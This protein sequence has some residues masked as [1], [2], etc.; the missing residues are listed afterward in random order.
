MRETLLR[1]RQAAT[2]RHDAALARWPDRSGDA[3][4]RE[5]TAV[6]DDLDRLAREA[7]ALD[8]DPVE[9]ARTWRYLGDACFDLA[10][11][12]DRAVL[13]RGADAY[14]RAGEVLG[15]ADP[16]E[17]AK[18]DFNWG[19]TLRAVSGGTDRALLEE[20]RLRYEFARETFR[21]LQPALVPAVG[22]ALRTLEAQLA[23]L[24]MYEQAAGAVKRLE[25]IKR[26]L[27]RGGA[28]AT[29]GSVREARRQL[30][31]FRASA[32][33]VSTL[34]REVEGLLDGFLAALYG[35]DPGAVPEAS[36]RQIETLKRALAAPAGS[37]EAASWHALA[38]MLRDR[39]DADVAAEK[40]DPARQQVLAPLLDELEALCDEEPREVAAIMD[41]L[42]R[43]RGLMDRILDIWQR[44]AAAPAAGPET[45]ADRLLRLLGGVRI[46]LGQETRE[47]N[48][49]S[50]ERQAARGLFLREG[51]AEAAVREAGRDEAR[52]LALEREVLRPLALDVHTFGLRRH[53]TLAEP[54][55][56]SGPVRPD[57]NRV[58]FV[59]DA[60]VRALVA[61]ACDRLG[62]TL[63]PERRSPY[64][65]SAPWDDL[66]AAHVTVFDLGVPDGRDLAAVC[67]ELGLALALGVPC[68]LV[69][70]DAHEAPFNVDV[71]VH[72]RLGGTDDATAIARMLDAAVYGA[73][74]ADA[75]GSVHAT[76]ELAERRF[77][78]PGAPAYVG[79]AV[80]ELAEASDDPVAARARLEALI[81]FVRTERSP[82][83]ARPAGAANASAPYLLTP[84]WAGAYPGTGPPRCFHV[85]RFGPA[86]ADATRE[87]L[88]AVCREAG[89]QYR[90]ADE[91]PDPSVIRSI[92]R[93][94]AQATVVVVDLTEV[95]PNVALELGLARALGRRFRAVAQGNLKRVLF[96]AIRNLQIF[97]YDPNDIGGSLG[98]LVRSELLEARGGR[99][100]P[101][102]A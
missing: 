3:F 65:D 89:A 41:W 72:V 85:T 97:K 96:P 80:R 98:A 38:R 34:R 5:M 40:I 27:T 43:L 1:R 82:A 22:Q 23:V 39:Y 52:L 64:P 50:L 28:G 19:N 12:K 53:L 87:A 44:R 57:P 70:R 56:P 66:R 35:R 2:E 14:E 15:E 18:L 32:R 31:E 45:S 62:L 75:H 25:E 78:N 4:A 24:A 21:Q 102:A 73:P 84:T 91:L 99:P 6:V 29:P 69:L 48:L 68:A 61:R 88:R 95:G 63:A 26:T 16:L 13:E 17:R 54:N 90:R 33:G 30:S 76:I 79:Q 58:V 67:Y 49:G 101:G 9:R 51:R 7:D 47:P 55:W 60:E 71:A 81:G 20:T 42:G 77:G 10:R 37:G 11:G 46:F 83:G 86:W 92:W 93:E 8:A 94:I 74:R 59:G 100:A 36:R